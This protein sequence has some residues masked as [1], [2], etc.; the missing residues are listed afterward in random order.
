MSDK[1][2][3][4]E[5]LERMIKE[6]DVEI[7]KLRAEVQEGRAEEER[8]KLRI[9]RLNPA[10]RAAMKLRRVFSDY[11]E[12][13]NRALALADEDTGALEE[14]VKPSPTPMPSGGTPRATP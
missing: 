9:R 14:P 11:F 5:I 3:Y 12:D 4:R 2:K 10:V 6:R 13:L 1:D 7:E 8:L